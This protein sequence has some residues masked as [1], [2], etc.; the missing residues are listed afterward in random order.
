MQKQVGVSSTENAEEFVKSNF[1][2]ILLYKV[3]GILGI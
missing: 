1:N 2:I 3:V